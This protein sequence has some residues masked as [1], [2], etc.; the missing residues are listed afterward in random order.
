MAQRS[1]T[2]DLFR[3]LVDNYVFT[4]L[5]CVPASIGFVYQ[6]VT[7]GAVGR[8]EG[9]G[10]AVATG[11]RYL[12]ASKFARKLTLTCCFTARLWLFAN[13]RLAEHERDAFY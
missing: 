9:R 1:E 13:R 4:W 7:T 5:L 2:T 10:R 11:E 8:P 6:F 3:R 12:R